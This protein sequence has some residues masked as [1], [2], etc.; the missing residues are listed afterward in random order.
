MHVHCP[1]STANTNAIQGLCTGKL[2][3]SNIINYDL[4]EML[5]VLPYTMP[6]I[7]I[8]VVICNTGLIV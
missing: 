1:K 4:Y 8:P 2:L 6:L 3:V 7:I 5:T